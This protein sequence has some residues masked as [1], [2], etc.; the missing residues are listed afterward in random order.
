MTPRELETFPPVTLGQIRGQIRSHGCRGLLVY[1]ESIHCNH[2]VETADHPQSHFAHSLV[3]NNA[4]DGLRHIAR[5]I[6]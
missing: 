2:S 1:C 6:D 5:S 4:M 3:A